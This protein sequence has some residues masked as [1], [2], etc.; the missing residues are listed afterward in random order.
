[1]FL[2]TAL[3]GDAFI[4]VSGDRHLLV[5]KEYAGVRIVDA[6]TFAAELGRG[7]GG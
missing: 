1:M 6:A 4:V 5:M 3:A 7:G 2:A